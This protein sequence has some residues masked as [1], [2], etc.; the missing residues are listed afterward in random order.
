MLNRAIWLFFILLRLYKVVDGLRQPI[1]GENA[2]VRS[3]EWHTL[4]VTVQNTHFQVFF[5]DQSLFEAD[6]TTLRQAGKIGLSTKA[7]S[8]TVF[9]NL[10]IESHDAQK[11][12]K[13]IS[14]ITVGSG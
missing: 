13:E 8:V 2:N 9:D 4:R 10:H 1:A 3:G 12:T 6:D 7:D 14:I 5:D 11:D